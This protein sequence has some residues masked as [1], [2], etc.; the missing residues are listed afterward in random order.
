MKVKPWFSTTTNPYGVQEFDILIFSLFHESITVFSM[1]VKVWFS[2]AA[3]QSV[4][5]EFDFCPFL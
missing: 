2:T 4:L 3:N 5:Q 1:K